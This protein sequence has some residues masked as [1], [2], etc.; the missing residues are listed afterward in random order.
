MNFRPAFF[1]TV[2]TAAAFAVL[3]GLFYRYETKP[4]SS[5]VSRGAQLATT[6]GCYACH[7][8]SIDDPR[9][10][11][12]LRDSA[13]E[14]TGIAPIW[15]EEHSAQSIITWVTHGVPESKRASHENLLMQM[16]AYGDDGHLT[17]AE[18]ADIAAWALAVGL[19]GFQGYDNLDE[20][21]PELTAADVTELAEGEL[22]LLGDRLSRKVGCYQCHGELGQGRI[23]NLA[24]FK[25]YIPGFQ[26]DDFLKLTDNGNPVEI[27]HWIEHGRGR[28]IESGLMGGLAQ[29]YFDAQAIPMPGYADV[30]S[31]PEIDLLV[32]YVQWLHRQG[33]MD[34]TAIESFAALLDDN[35]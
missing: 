4:E 30:L 7:G 10:N 31:D 26:G 33:P 11:F 27:R 9:A 5:P 13:W 25:R 12:R 24:S 15:E 21:M 20:D 19:K 8:T 34:A 3:V 28:D 23:D 35:L 17:E 32:A 16:P 14:P 2:G 1:V 22:V 18:I 6:A 29:G